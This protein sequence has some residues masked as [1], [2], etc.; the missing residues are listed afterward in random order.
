[1][2]K[3]KVLIVEDS[4]D[5][6]ELLLRTLRQA[7]YAPEHA[8]VA[9]QAELAAELDANP[10]DL[11]VSD[12]SMPGF[13]G[14]EALALVQQRGLDVPFI[15]VSATIGEETAVEAMRAGAKDY[16]VKG[17]IRRLI[18]AIERELR[19]AEKRRD[20][21]QVAAQMREMEDQLRQS[22]KMEA[23]GQLTGGLAHDFRNILG[24]IIGNL[25]L[26]RERI[27]GDGEACELVDN[28]LRASLK[29][30][31]LNNSLLAFARRQ[32]LNPQP[33]DI[34][35]TLTEMTKLLATTVGG[36]IE[37]ALDVGQPIG[38]AVV[39]R[40]QLESAM[41]NLAINA[42]DA[43]PEGGNLT[44]QMRSRVLDEGYA[45]RNKDVAPG[46]YIEIA[47][48]DT[49]IGMPPDVVARAFEPF[50]TTKGVGKGTG[51]G[52][53]ML[54]GFIKQ[55]G[56]HVELASIEGRGTT[57]RLFLPDRQPHAAAGD[58]AHAIAAP[59]RGNEHVLVVE[60]NG[61]LRN[62]AVR[63]LRDLG[64][65]VVEASNG[66]AALE[67]LRTPQPVDLLFTDVLMP[68]GLD[69]PTL[70][71]EAVKLRPQLKVLFTSGFTEA[72]GETDSP[73]LQKPYRKPELAA[74]LRA[75]LES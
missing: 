54:Y 1:M 56:G 59:L 17:N 49:G 29:G 64:Y 19:E 20:G 68:G 60:D 10:W 18:P 23:V 42:R 62:I 32:P 39:D 66:L 33:I 41:L 37:I 30:S 67:I 14:A 11:I 73:L 28:A 22:Q 34:V 15:F 50:F 46:R 75:A 12:Y 36:K 3:L 61:D 52:L 5:D 74:R 43:M 7:G 51:L 4:A 58:A 69:G 48:S 21:A 70:A 26:L 53:S 8:T 72:R 63:Q 24:V 71:R 44:I 9:S 25:D 38:H 6:A 35:Q 45:L 47:V 55:S 16:L 31:D 13:T 27:A 2:R 57:V 65:E 40:A